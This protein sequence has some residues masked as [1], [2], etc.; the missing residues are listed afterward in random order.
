[1]FPCNSSA[2]QEAT[3][4]S[5]SGQIRQLEVWAVCGGLKVTTCF[6]LNYDRPAQKC[7]W[8]HKALPSM[9]DGQSM[10]GGLIEAG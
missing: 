4:W 5:E 3:E 9:P 6:L 2:K 10:P 1:M 8:A 7:E